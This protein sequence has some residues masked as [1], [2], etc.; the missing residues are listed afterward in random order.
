VLALTTAFQ[1]PPS[2][3]MQHGLVA[4]LH[5]PRTLQSN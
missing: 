2:L 5:Y 1:M 3:L 4:A